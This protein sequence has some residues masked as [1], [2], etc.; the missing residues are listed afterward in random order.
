MPIF[1]AGITIAGLSG[2][3]QNNIPLQAYLQYATLETAPSSKTL[4]HISP[5][6]RQRMILMMNQFRAQNMQNLQKLNEPKK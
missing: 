1:T 6:K 2:H 4:N 3:W 5:E